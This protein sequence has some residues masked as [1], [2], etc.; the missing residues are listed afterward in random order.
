M[1][2]KTIELNRE[3]SERNHEANIRNKL[4]ERL[5]DLFYKGIIYQKGKFDEKALE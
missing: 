4:V 5:S 2:K 1:I 3:L